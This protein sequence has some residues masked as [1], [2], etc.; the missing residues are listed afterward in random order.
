MKRRWIMV[1]GLLASNVAT[2][3]GGPWPAATGLTAVADSALT[4]QTNPAGMA[5]LTDSD[6]IAQI[7]VVS[8]QSDDETSVSGLGLSSSDEDSGVYGGPLFYYVR[9]LNDRLNVGIS[10]SV[11]AGFGD[12]YGSGSASRYLVEEWSL[13]YVSL[14]PA[15][16]YRLNDQWSVGVSVPINYAKFDLEN[17]V[18]NPGAADGKMELE[19]DGVAASFNVGVLYELTDTTRVGFNYRSEAEMDLEGD[20][21]FSGLSTATRDLL[22]TSGA[23]N[24]D[25]E[26][27]SNLPPMIMV[28]SYHEFEN[29]VGWA[30]DIGQIQW[31]EFVL[32]EFG[33]FNGLRAERDSSYDDVWAGS[34][35]VSIPL[36]GRWT[37]GLGVAYM[38][39]P[40]EDD[41][42][43]LGFR[44]DE[45]WL[46]GAGLEFD[47]GN[48][49]SIAANLSFIDLGDG[50][51]QSEPIPVIGTVAAE[52]D[53]HWG[54]MLDLQFRWGK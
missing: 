44:I 41:T 8:T 11:P 17:A 29:G 13:V 6:F 50:R 36:G 42:R 12:D 23:L 1:I 26:I 53:E 33:Y 2:A 20:P 18:F 52:Y 43:T 5:R 46:I 39:T 47:R 9:P 37:L 34:T 4:A 54:V 19:A 21:D 28:G 45:T 14:V 40:V 24:A 30:I 15:I 51:V 35:G 38:E 3:D 16:S 31:S 10:L 49:R 22:A 27:G 25:V 48:G 32:T 7:T